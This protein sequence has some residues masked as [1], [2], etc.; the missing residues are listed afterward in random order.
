VFNNSSVLT[1]TL[2]AAVS[3]LIFMPGLAGGNQGAGIFQADYPGLKYLFLPLPCAFAL[4]VI[5]VYGKAWVI[6]ARRLVSNL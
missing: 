3:I 1:I 5:G 6:W 4:S 2:N